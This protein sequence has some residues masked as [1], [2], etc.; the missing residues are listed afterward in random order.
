MKKAAV[1]AVVQR[2]A[3]LCCEAS[4]HVQAVANG[5]VFAFL[6]RVNVPQNLDVCPE[7][8]GRQA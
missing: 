8:H 5:A 1:I 6:S 2:D 3:A 7:G 4:Q